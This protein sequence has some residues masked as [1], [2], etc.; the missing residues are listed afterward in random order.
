MCSP[1]EQ[2]QASVEGLRS[3]GVTIPHDLLGRTSVLE[4]PATR[5]DNSNKNAISE[6]WLGI[7]SDELIHQKFMEIFPSEY[8]NGQLLVESGLCTVRSVR[9]LCPSYQEAEKG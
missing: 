4:R 1:A 6:P 3:G 5:A 7:A 8:R 2:L 9:F